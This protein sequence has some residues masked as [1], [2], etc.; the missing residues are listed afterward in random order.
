[1]ASDP[2]S[3]TAAGRTAVDT[4]LPHDQLIPAIAGQLESTGEYR[5]TFAST[6]AQRLVD[7]RWA[8]LGAGRLIGRRVRVVVHRG[9]IAPGGTPV[10]VRLTCASTRGPATGPTPGPT[11]PRQRHEAD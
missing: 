7:L 11:I 1:M 9:A 6:D 4:Q 3:A 8:A 10:T 5:A 2:G